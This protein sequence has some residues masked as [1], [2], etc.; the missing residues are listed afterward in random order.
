[1][2]IYTNRFLPEKTIV[3]NGA[4]KPTSKVCSEWLIHIDDENLIPEVPL[5]CINPQQ[6]ENKFYKKQCHTFHAD[7]YDRKKGIVK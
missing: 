6:K 7:A 1:M 5:V 4:N 2:A 3:G